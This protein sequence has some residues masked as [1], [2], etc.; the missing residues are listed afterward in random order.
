[1]E[2]KR[3]LVAVESPD[4]NLLN[5]Y[6]AVSSVIYSFSDL[7]RKNGFEIWVNDM[8]LEDWEALGGSENTVLLPVKSYYRFFPKRIR[9][10]IKDI[11]KFKQLHKL[12]TSIGIISKP[13]VI[14][15]WISPCSSFSVDLSKKWQVPLISIFDHPYNEEYKFLFG[16]Y[17]FFKNRI[18]KHEKRVLN[19]SQSVIIYSKVVRDYIQNKYNTKT[20]FYYK[21]FAD[22]KRMSFSDFQRDMSVINLGYIGSFFNWHRIDDLIEAFLLLDQEEDYN[23]NLYLIGDGPEYDRLINSVKHDRIIF[24]G[25]KDGAELE[26]LLKRIHIGIIPNALWF[27]GPV[28]L[29]QYSAAQMP[30]ICRRTPTIEELTKQ[31]E[32]FLFFE[33][34]ETLVKQFKVLLN[35]KNK[36]QELGMINQQFAREN[37]SEKEYYSFFNKIFQEI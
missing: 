3:I 32:G 22:F 14:I 31:T 6:S 9:E 4:F 25:R 29:F 8:K 27:Q 28:K 1:M 15:S 35:N 18:N 10:L 34:I 2:V 26:N 13:D 23:C 21:A 16:F 37:F 33:N 12:E 17:P 24:T 20:K 19:N 30:V 5:T 7:L 11:F 36:I